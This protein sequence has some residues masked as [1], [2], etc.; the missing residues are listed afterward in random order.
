MPAASP[1]ATGTACGPP[2]VVSGEKRPFSPPCSPHPSK[3]APQGPDGSSL[4]R[5]LTISSRMPEGNGMPAGHGRPFLRVLPY[6]FLPTARET[7]LPHI[8]K[9]RGFSAPS[10]PRPRGPLGTRA[11]CRAAAPVHLPEGSAL[12]GGWGSRREGGPLARRPRIPP[13]LRNRRYLP[14]C[15]HLR[16]RQRIFILMRWPGDRMAYGH[17]PRPGA[18]KARHGARA[19]VSPLSRLRARRTGKCRPRACQGPF[20]T[21][22][23]LQPSSRGYYE[24]YQGRCLEIPCGAPPR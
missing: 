17:A 4:P 10:L 18:E 24:L 23:P 11:A 6:A 3:N 2:P 21:I 14:S 12:G 1:V 22:S 15:P 9:H 19:R 16:K 7:I 20:F 5:P 13:S 8:A